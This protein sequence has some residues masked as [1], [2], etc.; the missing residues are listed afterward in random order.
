M[1]NHQR[2]ISE[3]MKDFCEGTNKRGFC[4]KPPLNFRFRRVSIRKTVVLRIDLFVYLSVFRHSTIPNFSFLRSFYALRLRYV[5]DRLE[6][7]Q[8]I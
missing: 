6:S 2:S 1:E 7:I 3:T 8:D 4:A 5:R